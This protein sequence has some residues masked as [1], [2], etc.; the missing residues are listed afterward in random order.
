MVATTPARLR[1][2]MPAR[3]ATIL[4]P[5]GDVLSLPKHHPHP[6]RGGCATLP[7]A[8][9]PSVGGAVMTAPAYNRRYGNRHLTHISMLLVV[10]RQFTDRR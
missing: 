3:R 8:T 9:F 1:G 7:R 4:P 6:Y 5:A 10:T 2:N